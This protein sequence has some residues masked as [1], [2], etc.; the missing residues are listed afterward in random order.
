MEDI[1]NKVKDSGLISLDLAKFNPKETIVGIDIADQLWQ[2]LVL[3]EKD[4][5]TWIKENNWSSFSNQAVYIYCSADAFVPTWAYMLIASALNEFTNKY[6]VGTSLDL[7]K[8][9]VESNIK[10]EPLKA[11]IDGRVIVKGCSDIPAPDFAMVT[12]INHLQPVVKSI[13]YGEPC[14]TVPVYKRK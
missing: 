11:Y 7:Q 10:N 1:V 9:L 6:I 2:G 14:S 5:R 12:L 4:F 3:K 13:M 8:K